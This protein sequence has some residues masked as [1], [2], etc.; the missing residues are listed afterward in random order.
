ML[1]GLY[2]HDLY[3]VYSPCVLKAESD[4]SYPRADL[5]RIS[6]ILDQHDGLRGV[7][8]TVNCKETLLSK[9]IS[10]IVAEPAMKRLSILFAL[11]VLSVLLGGCVV[12][13]P[14]GGGDGGY[15]HDRGDRNDRRDDDNRDDHRRDK[16]GKDHQGD[17]GGNEYRGGDNRY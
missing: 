5:V 4:P 9:A 3:S 7:E 13:A 17:R 2:E 8:R 6:S 11:A 15:S 10:S 12:A 14:Y 1:A 16:D